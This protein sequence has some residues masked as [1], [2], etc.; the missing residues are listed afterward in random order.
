M[1]LTPAEES[2]ST[3]AVGPSPF[4]PRDCRCADQ[5]QAAE[6]CPA[7]A[8]TA[9]VTPL[10]AL[11]ARHILRDG[12]I[13]LLALKPSLWFIPL[14]SLRFIAAVAILVLGAIA[15]EGRYNREWFYIEAA[16]FLVA[17][18]LVAVGLTTLT[19]GLSEGDVSVVYPLVASAPL[20]TLVFTAMLLRGVELLNWRIVLGAV[21]VVFGVIYLG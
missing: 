4:R 19:F 16:I 3:P 14:S 1:R 6:S 15:W 2:A 7:A 9:A 20:F 21:A 5:L 12:E 8:P 18:S 10:G 17:G 11:L 13:V